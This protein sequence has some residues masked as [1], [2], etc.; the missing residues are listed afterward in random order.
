[1]IIT[2][3]QVQLATFEKKLRHS[4]DVY[5]SSPNTY[6]IDLYDSLSPSTL[7]IE[8]EKEGVNVLAAVSLLYDEEMDGWYLG[9]KIDDAATVKDLVFAWLGE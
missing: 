2:L 4:E 6:S 8:L 1:M 5:A 9:E 7:E 3:N